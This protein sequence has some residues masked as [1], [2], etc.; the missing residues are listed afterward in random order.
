LLAAAPE[1][2][3]FQLV[4]DR[5]CFHVFDEPAERSKF[6]ARMAEVLAPDGRSNVRHR[7]RHFSTAPATIG[8]ATTVKKVPSRLAFGSPTPVSASR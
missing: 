4:F 7:R 3:P 8:A 6:A 1:G 5:G 2:G